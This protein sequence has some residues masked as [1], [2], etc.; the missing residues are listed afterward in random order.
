M[1]RAEMEIGA[2]SN[3]LRREWE[4]CWDRKEWQRELA[5]S[6]EEENCDDDVADMGTVE[7][8]LENKSKIEEGDA[9]S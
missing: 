5:A 6:K 8:P 4:R 3:E 2:V 1:D 7:E 9:A